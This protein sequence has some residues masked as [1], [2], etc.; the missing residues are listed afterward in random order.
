[1]PDRNIVVL[2]APSGAGKTTIAHRVM[3]AMPTMQ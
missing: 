3:E 1:M 2:T